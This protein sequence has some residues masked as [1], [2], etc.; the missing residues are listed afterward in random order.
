MPVEIIVALVAA[1]PATL[2]AWAAVQANKK[3]STNGSSKHIGLLVEA[4]AERLEL[5]N[6]RVQRIELHLNHNGNDICAVCG[7]IS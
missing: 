3:V 2:A 7:T 4:N 5:L 6:N 1:G